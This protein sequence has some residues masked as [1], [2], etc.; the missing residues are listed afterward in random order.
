[1]T[2]RAVKCTAVISFGIIGLGGLFS[3]PAQAADDCLAGPKGTTPQGSHWYYRLEKGTG[4]KCWYLG[5]QGAKV[6]SSAPA[7]R[8]SSPTP[9]KS[10]DASK[11]AEKDQQQSL[12]PSV[13]NARAELRATAP[14]QAAASNPPSALPAPGLLSSQV[15]APSAS[16]SIPGSAQTLASRW[17]D[18]DSFRPA[19][20]PQVLAQNTTTQPS[21]DQAQ[22]PRQAT[23]ASPAISV[24]AQ[25]TPSQSISAVLTPARIML[26]AIFVILAIAAIFARNAFRY[27]AR[28]K[29]KIT[30][31]RDIWS[32][33]DYGDQSTLPYEEMVTPER[34]SR[35]I[36]QPRQE[37]DEIEYLLRRA[38]NREARQRYSSS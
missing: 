35:N 38:A 36:G 2:N 19:A 18:P 27:F 15:S 10:A 34:R 11:P 28:P 4:R 33:A 22:Q 16:S 3:I 23:P 17:P 8:S 20:S 29:V 7:A 26:A 31:R 5:S 30:G 13:A 6:N 25:S 9:D 24:Q 1:M 14:A 12:Q 37:T 21:G 32:Q